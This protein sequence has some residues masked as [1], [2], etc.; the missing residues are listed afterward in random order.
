MVETKHSEW[1]TR[2]RLIDPRLA[3]AGWAVRTNSQ[4]MGC[5]LSQQLKLKT[6]ELIMSGLLNYPANH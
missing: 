1:L 3:A 2:K 4:K 5:H 6:I